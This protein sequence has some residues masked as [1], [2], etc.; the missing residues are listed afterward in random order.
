[1]GS[2]STL[3]RKIR[4]KQAVV[5]RIKETDVLLIDEVSMLSCELLETLDGVARLVREKDELMG[6][7]QIVAVGDFFQVK[8]V[9]F[10][11]MSECNTRFLFSSR[12]F[13]FSFSYL[14]S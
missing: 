7:L 3:V 1:M 2:I 11:V 12:T 4:K 10:F 8:S 13:Y 5:D 14:Q 6:G 9:D